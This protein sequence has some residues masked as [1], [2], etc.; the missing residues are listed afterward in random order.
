MILLIYSFVCAGSLLLCGL[1]CSFG[2]QELP[3]VV[4]AFLIA[5]ASLAVERRLQG[6][7][8][9]ELWL[10]GPRAQAQS[11]DTQA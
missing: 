4:R 9:Q 7:W 6:V 10:P 11:C 8:A 3:G 1:L 5:G 2:E